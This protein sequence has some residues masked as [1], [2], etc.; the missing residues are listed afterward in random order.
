MAITLGSTVGSYVTSNLI[1]Y[2]DASKS[3][4]AL[5]DL[6]GESPS[7]TY[8]NSPSYVN[9]NGLG[10]YSF[11]G[12]GQYINIAGI[13]ISAGNWTSPQTTIS[14]YVYIDPSCSIGTEHNLFTAENAIELKA[15]N[16]GNG[17]AA[18][19]FAGNPWAWLADTRVD[20]GK[21]MMITYRHSTATNTADIIINDDI[22]S[23]TAISGGLAVGTSST[24]FLTLAGRGNG[25]DAPF[26][27]LISAFMVYNRVLS[28]SEIRQN[29]KYLSHGLAFSDGSVQGTS[30]PD[31][32][33][34]LGISTYSTVG[35]Y[36][37]TKL[38]TCTKVLVTVTGGGGGG[39]GYAESGG[40]GGYSE[41]L[42]DVTSISSTT[43]TIGGGGA[44]TGYY[45]GS[46]AGGTSSFGGYCSASGGYGANNNH[47]HTGGHGGVGS[48][49]DV[50]LQ[51]GTGTGHGSVPNPS[52][53]I[54]NGGGSFWGSGYMT[55]HSTTAA[56]GTSA[57]GAG[58]CGET[59]ARTNAGRNGADGM[60]T[61]HA[62]T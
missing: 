28:V 7:I 41:K 37:W 47:S 25:P 6:S 30:G 12:A 43:V 8:G 61:I 27:G 40:S 32:G 2:L 11:N 23:T 29:Y 50:N 15:V 4:S 34:L 44:G 59:T 54:G 17:K 62:Y 1:C 60:V 39:A 20:M 57:P 35:S 36:T 14:I 55:S 46:G 45:S 5:T 18:L 58:G 33:K 13:N 16:L 51:G 31:Q 49:G 38:A 19:S 24:P 22:A 3:G 26:K 53:P 42:I 9:S 56:W 21:W 52:S 48:N 10:Y